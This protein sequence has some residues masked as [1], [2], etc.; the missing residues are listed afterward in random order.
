MLI[1]LHTH[2]YP[3]S[4]DGF[5]GV[6][7]LIEGA[8]SHGLDGVC[9]TDYDA[10]W[11]M[12]EVRCLGRKHDF[13]LLP[14]CEINTD[15]GHVIVFS[16]ERYVFGLHKLDF[17]RQE[18]RRDG[19]VIIAAH[20]Y[21]RRFLEE[22]ARQPSAREEMLDRATGDEFF[23]ICNAIESINGRAKP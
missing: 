11:S 1:D 21:R 6:D 16:L 7:D 20:P 18:V 12:D 15:T 10:F 22:P 19:A 9:L 4:D 8:K 14:G 5:M 13:L 23:G 17:L 3:K 2:S